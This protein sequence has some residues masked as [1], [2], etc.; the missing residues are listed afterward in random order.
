MYGLQSILIQ[1][2]FYQNKKSE[3]QIND[4]HLFIRLKT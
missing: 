3:N 4:F 1:S 2:I